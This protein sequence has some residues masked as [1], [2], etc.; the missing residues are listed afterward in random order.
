MSDLL[1]PLQDVFR[2]V[3]DDPELTIGETTDASAVEDWDSLMHINLI[4][5]V[6]KAFA[7]RFTTGEIAKLK[8]PGENVGSLLALIRDKRAPSS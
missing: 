2:D 7:I 5:A 4:V 8:R 1:A 6:E 3:F